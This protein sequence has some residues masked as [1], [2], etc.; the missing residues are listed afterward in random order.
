A[1]LSVVALFFYLRVV[2]EAYVSDPSSDETVGTSPGITIAVWTCVAVVVG[3]GAWPAPLL[4]AATRA[5]T[6]F[7]SGS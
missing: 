5:A 2:K 7:L 6:L 3:M 1:L 4:A